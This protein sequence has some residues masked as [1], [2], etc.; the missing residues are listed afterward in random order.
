MGGGGVCVGAA[1]KEEVAAFPLF[2][3]LLEWS[4]RR[5]KEALGPLAAMVGMSLAGGLRAV[6]ATAVIAD[7]AR[8]H[9]RA[10]TR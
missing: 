8:A 2:L 10:S 7:P 1:A 3:A 6:H 9:R 5:K 4:T